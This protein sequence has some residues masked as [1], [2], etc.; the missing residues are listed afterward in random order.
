MDLRARRR[1]RAC[2]LT[3][4]VVKDSL[5]FFFANM[6]GNIPILDRRQL[7][8]QA[9]Y[10]EQNRDTYCLL[11]SLCAFMMLQPGMSMP[12][13]DPYN[14]DVM[15]GANLVSSNLLLEETLRVRKGYEYLDS[16]TLNTLCTNFFIFGCYYG[17]EMHEKAWYYLREATTIMQMLGMHKEETYAQWDHVESSRRRRL[18]WL[19]FMTERYLPLSPTACLRVFT[20]C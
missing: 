11:T 5:E 16:P 4:E 1:A 12:A 15:P 13:G 17:M 8:Q 19:Y 18:Y 2:L 7:E 3:A 9:M 14:L 20:E 10:M 6:Y